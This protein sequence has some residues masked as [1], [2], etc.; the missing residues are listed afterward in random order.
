MSILSARTKIFETI[1]KT[2]ILEFR[3]R[4]NMLYSK[5]F[6]F[7]EGMGT[8][9]AVIDMIVQSERSRDTGKKVARLY[10]D[11]RKTFNM[12]NHQLLLKK[13][14]WPYSGWNPI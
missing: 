4:H 7:R 5:Q 3:D 9:T 2:R 11:L 14:S 12:V 10:I 8:S 13:L 1:V 6:G